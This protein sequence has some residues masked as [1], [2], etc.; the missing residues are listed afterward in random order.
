M[1]AGI[2]FKRVLPWAIIVLALAVAAVTSWQYVSR[3]GDGQNLVFCDLPEGCDAPAYAVNARSADEE[4][5]RKHAPIVYL[6][7]LTGTT[8][9]AAGSAIRPVPVETVLGNDEVVL[10]QEATV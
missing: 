8:C 3:D 7:P 5:A 4:L 10:Q 2:R 6:P 9:D 1:R